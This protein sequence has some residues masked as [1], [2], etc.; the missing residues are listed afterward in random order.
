MVEGATPFWVRYPTLYAFPEGEAKF[1]ANGWISEEHDKYLK[2]DF[3]E[4]VGFCS[5]FPRYKNKRG[6]DPQVKM[7]LDQEKIDLEAGWGLPVP[8]QAAAYISL[9]KYGKGETLFTSDMVF[10]MNKAIRWCER[11]FA[12]YM[13][14]SRI[15]TIEE[16]IS[17]L[18][19]SSS[20]GCPFNE[21]FATKKDLFENDPSIVEWLE[22]DWEALASDPK[23]TCIFSSSL[24]EELRTKEK[25]QQNSIRTFA[26]GATDA[27]VHGTRL[28]VDQN[29]KMYDSHLKTASCI[30]MT[31]LKGNWNKLYHK[32]NVFPNGYALDESQYDS[33]LRAYLLWACAKIR[34]GFLREED[35]TK[36]NYDR[37]R[38]YY[39]NLISCVILTPEGVLIMKKL[40]MPSGGVNT[41]TDNTL[42]LYILLSFAWISNAPE[43]YSSYACF[44]T[45]TAKALVGDDNTWT[46]SDQ[47][48]GF[49]NAQSIISTWKIVGITTTTDSVVARPA[50]ELDFLSAHTVFLDGVAIPLY[51]RDKLMQSL[52]YAPQKHITP[53]T[54]LQRVAAL[55]QCGWSD[56]PF[57][58]FCRGLIKW[59]FEEYD[60]I[61]KD[62]LRWIAAKSSILSDDALYTL[63]TGRKTLYPQAYQETQEKLLSLI[64]APMSAPAK[65]KTNQKKIARKNRRNRGPKKGNV[66]VQKKIVIGK[67]SRRQRRRRVRIGPGGH[68]TAKGSTQ[69][70]GMR[71]MNRR[72]C[73][74]EEDEFIGP[75]SG[76]T[77]FNA[78]PYPLNPG[79]ARTF[80]WLS[81]EAKLWER[82]VF[83]Y[84]EF[85]YKR[86][87]SEFATNGTTGKVMMNVDF[88]ASENP[89]S[90]KI[91]VEDSFPHSDGMPCENFKL[92][93]PRSQLHPKGEPKYVRTGG[94]P[95]AA[96]IKLYDAGNFFISTQGNQN[97]TEVGELRVRYRIRFEVPV[98]EAINTAPTNYSVTLWQKLLVPGLTTGAATNI[99]FQSVDVVTDGLGIAPS[100]NF[101]L[102]PG[103]Y[104]VDGTVVFTIAGGNLTSAQGAFQKNGTAVFTSSGFTC[105]AAAVVVANTLTLSPAYVVGNGIDQFQFI[106]AATFT[107]TCT[108]SAALRFTAI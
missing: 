32:L 46:V 34:F 100:N 69:N 2:S 50:E 47:C 107:G 78:V 99:N 71:M 65:A 1:H 11:Q 102:P 92:I 62:D 5:R 19:M 29:E 20:S 43:E 8:N 66:T 75:V 98:L 39:R 68:L 76:S 22:N 90:S 56:L 28:F 57:R 91:Q 87:V 7:Y 21:H 42:I 64:K 24:K 88:D 16:A 51:S 58:R 84:L 94:I 82:Y 36:E 41:V 106:V 108:F 79:Q 70:D 72:G 95:G 37:V 67:T 25:I 77:A 81:Q 17:R 61:L 52:L 101:V 35:R 26:A 53:E 89:P 31:P 13:S 4:I 10:K 23:W 103:N 55:L 74:V 9:S 60:D 48:H 73:V 38:T 93:V 18:D 45:N 27:T 59:L 3:F 33:S 80:P 105:A 49:F 63:Y 15:V 54:T 86:D 104:L 96:D 40:G 85:Y 6:V 83:E 12:P 97:S 30:G 44:E 14:E